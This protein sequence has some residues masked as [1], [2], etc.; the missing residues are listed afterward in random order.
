MEAVRETLA[1]S[2]SYF[3]ADFASVLS[4]EEEALY[5]LVAVNLLGQNS[6]VLLLRKWMG[7]FLTLFFFFLFVSLMRSDYSSD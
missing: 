6:S 1:E 4:G 3:E 7:K 5:S 2:G